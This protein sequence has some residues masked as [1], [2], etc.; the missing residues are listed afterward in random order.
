MQYGIPAAVTE[1]LVVTGMDPKTK[2]ARFGFR[3]GDVVIE[4][5]RTRVTTVAEFEKAYAKSGSQVLFLLW[6]KGATVFV[7]VPKPK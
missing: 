6:S 2:A 4:V 1:G 7:S 5:N 3:P